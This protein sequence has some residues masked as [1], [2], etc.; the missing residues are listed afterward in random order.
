MQVNSYFTTAGYQ[1]SDTSRWPG[2]ACAIILVQMFIGACAISSGGGIKAARTIIAL[3][4]AS[5][6]LYHHIHKNAIRPIKYAGTPLKLN[7]LLRCNLYIVMF[8][9]TFLFGALI[10]SI[11]LDL[12][13]AL[14]TSLA[15]LTN[16]GTYINQTA[17]TGIL[18][19][20]SIVSKITM[21][22][23]MLAGRLEIYPVILIFFKSFWKNDNDFL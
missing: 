22:F 23:L 13:T 9:V 19:D 10:L 18:D 16:T 2:A 12:N 1:I 8:V 17:T 4:T 5:R 20:Y 21:M 7:T 11:N 6:T 15:M 3:K 14:S